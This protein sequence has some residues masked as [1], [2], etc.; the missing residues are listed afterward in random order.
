VEG[1]RCQSRFLF[2]SHLHHDRA[3]QHMNKCMCL[4]AISD[5]NCPAGIPR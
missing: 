3:F 4:V 2:A 5:P 1:I